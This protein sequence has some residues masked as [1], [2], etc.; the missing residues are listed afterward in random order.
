MF[1]SP[2][3]MLLLLLIFFFVGV[4]LSV[5]GAKTKKFPKILVTLR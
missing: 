5:A 4:G 3:A 2:R 1:T